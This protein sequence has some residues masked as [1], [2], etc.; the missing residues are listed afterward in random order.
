M[1]EDLEKIS[2]KEFEHYESMYK[3]VDFLNKN[4]ESL[5]VAFGLAI[6][7]NK[8]VITIYKEK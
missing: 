1:I 5:G 6:K 8:D 2:C 4:L 3:V 7:D